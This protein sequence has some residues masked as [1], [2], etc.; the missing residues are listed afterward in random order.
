LHAHVVQRRRDGARSHCAGVARRDGY[1]DGVS[2]K[3]AYEHG[4]DNP[5]G[6]V[7]CGG[8]EELEG[9]ENGEGSDLGDETDEEALI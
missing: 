1:E 2:V 8:R 7:G 6:P 4:G 9:D 3:M 5:A